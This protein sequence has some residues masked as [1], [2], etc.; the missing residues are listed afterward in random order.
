MKYLKPYSEFSLNETEQKVVYPT[1]FAGM[2][3]GAIANIHSQILAIA[4]ELANEKIAR[5]PYRYSNADVKIGNIQEVDIAR[6]INLIFHSDWKKKMKDQDIRG[7]ARESIERA[8]KHDDR[9][10]KKNQRALRSINKK[11]DEYSMDLGKLGFS[12]E[13]KEK[14]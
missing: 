2:V 4:Q 13:P 12:R 6:A 7:W 3:R 11:K 14:M 5:N 1:N 10:N 9:A 8:T